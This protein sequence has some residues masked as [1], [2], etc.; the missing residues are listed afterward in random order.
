MAALVADRAIDRLDAPI[1]RVGTMDTPI[2]FAPECE[3]F[4]LPNEQRI[5]QAIR[6][7]MA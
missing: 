7:V 2:P 5:V 3:Q 4:V 6:E 1:K